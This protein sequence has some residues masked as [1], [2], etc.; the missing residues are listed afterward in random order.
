MVLPVFSVFLGF[1]KARREETLYMGKEEIADHLNR[2]G[3]FI[4]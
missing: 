4:R 3:S 1:K 2:D